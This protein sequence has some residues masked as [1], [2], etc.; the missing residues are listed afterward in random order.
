MSAAVKLS[1][2]PGVQRREGSFH[3]DANSNPIFT[4]SFNTRSTSES[5]ESTSEDA[6]TTSILKMADNELHRSPIRPN[7]SSPQVLR[8]DADGHLKPANVVRASFNAQTSFNARGSFNA[9]PKSRH[10]SISEGGF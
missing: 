10:G 6:L 4:E 7:S 2:A 3:R 5:S 9:R 8:V 1:Q